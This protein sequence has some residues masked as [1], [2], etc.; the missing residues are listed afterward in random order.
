MA[1][2]GPV[3]LPLCCVDSLDFDPQRV[4]ACRINQRIKDKRIEQHG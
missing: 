2:M 3:S 4:L 1:K